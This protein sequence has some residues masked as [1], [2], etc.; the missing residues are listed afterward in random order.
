MKKTDDSVKA[1]L[2]MRGDNEDNRPIGKSH[3]TLEEK[4]MEDED[5]RVHNREEVTVN[6]NEEQDIDEIVH[7]APT[8]EGQDIP[9]EEDLDDKV[10]RQ[11]N[12]DDQDRI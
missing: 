1:G 2:E 10:H 4:A 12:A 8:A 6:P 7:Q 3:G 5:E 11:G 9:H